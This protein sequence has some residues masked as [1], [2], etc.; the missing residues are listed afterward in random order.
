MKFFIFLLPALCLYI[1][2]N[3]IFITMSSYRTNIKPFCPKFTTPQ[4]FLHF[5]LKLENLFRS[6]TFYCLNYSRWTHHGYTLNQKMNMVVISAN[7]YKSNFKTL[8]NF[9]TY[10]FQSF[11]YFFIKNNPPVFGYTKWYRSTETLW[12]L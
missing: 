9:N 7:L 8:R 11:I 1:F 5:R 2:L 10:L 3:C 4:L 6:D 12:L